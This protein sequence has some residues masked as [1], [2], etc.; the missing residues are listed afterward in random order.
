MCSISGSDLTFGF[1]AMGEDIDGN[2]VYGI[3]AVLPLLW[4]GAYS[5]KSGEKAEVPY[6]GSACSGGLLIL[7]LYIS[8]MLEETAASGGMLVITSCTALI[9]LKAACFFSTGMGGY[10]VFL[11]EIE[12]KSKETLDV[13]WVAVKCI[14]KIIGLSILTAAL[15]LGVMQYFAT[16]KYEE[17]IQDKDSYDYS[18]ETKE[19][20]ENLG[21]DDIEESQNIEQK[22]TEKEEIENTSQDIPEQTI[23]ESS[24]EETEFIFPNSDSQY[25]LVDELIE[26]PMET[27]RIGRNE[28]FA[29]HGYIFK[30]ENLQKYFNSTS[31]YEGTV[32]GEDFNMEEE[33]NKYEKENVEL[34]KSIEDGTEY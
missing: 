5:Y 12:Y 13:V 1:Q 25:L 27:L 30:D 14:G 3:I 21:V 33:F 26:L 32:K 24:K 15:V 31:W 28:I 23:Q 16:D 8:S 2:W 7:M 20:F 4:F 11:E 10:L 6:S 29:R 9:V 34:I 18:D 17:L 22:K 19:D